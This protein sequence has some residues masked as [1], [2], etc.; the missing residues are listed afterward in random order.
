MDAHGI[1][2]DNYLEFE[3]GS[4]VQV[5]GIHPSLNYFHNGKQWID[6]FRFKPIPL[7]EDYL[8]AFDFK[9]YKNKFI[10]MW[11]YR[12]K[13][14]QYFFQSIATGEIFSC[15]FGQHN[16]RKIQYVHQLQN[17]NVLF[18]G[19]FLNFKHPKS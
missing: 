15:D 14:N 19:K 6:T 13:G 8:R 12:I 1:C 5:K 16:V 18:R 9:K 2:I 17:L 11:I 3:D 7:T 10:G 4:I